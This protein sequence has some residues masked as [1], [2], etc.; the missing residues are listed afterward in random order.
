MHTYK[1][2]AI[3]NYMNNTTLISQF[4]IIKGQTFYDFEMISLAIKYYSISVP[5]KSLAFSISR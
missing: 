2:I 5:L 4:K 3:Y 1:G